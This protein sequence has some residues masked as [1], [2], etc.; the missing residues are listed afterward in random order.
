MFLIDDLFK[1]RFDLAKLFIK[2]VLSNWKLALYK[3][4]I[5]III[6]PKIC[7]L[8]WYILSGVLCAI[9]RVSYVLAK[10]YL[11]HFLL[12]FR[13]TN[14]YFIFVKIISISTALTSVKPGMFHTLIRILLL[15]PRCH[16]TIK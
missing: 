1:S 16:F 6:K 3:Y 13:K 14:Y 12:S 2:A 5:I 15:V 9:Y 11:F 8:N 7:I 4:I 10:I